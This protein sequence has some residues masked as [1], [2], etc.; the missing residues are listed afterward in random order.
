[1]SDFFGSLYQNIVL[2]QN[3]LVILAVTTTKTVYN[4]MKSI[5]YENIQF[6]LVF[7]YNR[8]YGNVYRRC[9]NIY[10]KSAFVARTVDRVQYGFFLLCNKIQCKKTE[11]FSKYWS[12]V[13]AMTKSHFTYKNYDI[14]YN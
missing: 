13:S 2:L 10:N 7:Y 4:K 9:T 11:P 12:C 6:D 1:M 5:D 3:A 14:R 8:V